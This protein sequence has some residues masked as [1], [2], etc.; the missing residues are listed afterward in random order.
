MRTFL[1]FCFADTPN[2]LVDFETVVGG[3]LLNGQVEFGVVQYI[4]GNL[5]G[6]PWP[7]GAI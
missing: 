2:G 1:G 6:D 7:A 3:E 5:V 4:V